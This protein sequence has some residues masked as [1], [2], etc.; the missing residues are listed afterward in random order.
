MKKMEN[1]DYFNLVMTLSMILMFILLGFLI[2]V[3]LKFEYNKPCFEE[4]AEN[5]CKE[6]GYYFGRTDYLITKYSMVCLENERDFDGIKYKF[7]QS[8]VDKCLK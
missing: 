7:I 2:Y 3:D 1:I 8:E 4:I 5:Y 6:R